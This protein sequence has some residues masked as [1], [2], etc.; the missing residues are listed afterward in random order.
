MVRVA[1]RSGSTS[2]RPSLTRSTAR[3]ILLTSTGSV[4]PLRLRTRIAVRVVGAAGVVGVAGVVGIVVV[5]GLVVSSGAR[6][7][8]P[9]VV[10]VMLS[11]RELDRLQ[12]PRE[13]DEDGGR[14]PGI[15]RAP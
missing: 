8:V 13:G 10:V 9:S 14:A 1:T 6:V 11:P 5:V 3:T 7:R 2:G 4:S 12:R 15:R